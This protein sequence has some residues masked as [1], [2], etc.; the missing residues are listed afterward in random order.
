MPVAAVLPLIAIAVTAVLRFTLMSSHVSHWAM[1]DLVVSLVAGSFTVFC[2]YMGRTINKSFLCSPLLHESDGWGFAVAI[3]GM[4]GIFLYAGTSLLG[5]V[6]TEHLRF[7]LPGDSDPNGRLFAI[8]QNDKVCTRTLMC[9]VIDPQ[10]VTA[11]SFS[12]P[13]GTS[14]VSLHHCPAGSSVAI[15]RP[16]GPVFPVSARALRAVAESCDF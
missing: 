9:P 6:M 13:E 5:I 3:T 16:S 1:R 11:A 8:L 4:S 12:R 7:A 15:P 10:L 2:L 14:H